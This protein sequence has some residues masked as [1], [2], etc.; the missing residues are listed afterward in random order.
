MLHFDSMT[1]ENFGPYEG[2]Q[3]IDFSNKKGV[4]IIWGNNGRG[5]TTLLNAFRYALFNEVFRR[6]GRLENIYKMENSEAAVRGEHGFSVTL[7]M[8]NDD[9]H[10]ELTR[11]YMPSAGV[12]SPKD[13]E[14][15]EM[16]SFLKK[17]G[18]ILSPEQKEHELNVIMPIEVSRFFLFDA[19][20]LQEYEDLLDENASDGE[21]IKEA[22]ERILGL[23]VLRNGMLDIKNKLD[24]LDRAKKNLGRNNDKAKQYV[25]ELDVMDQQI[26]QHK[27]DIASHKDTLQELKNQ[28]TKL[29]TQMAS[30]EKVRGWIAE[31]K[32]ADQEIERVKHDLTNIESSLK[33]TLGNAWKSMLGTTVR[34]MSKKIEDEKEVLESKKQRRGVADHFLREMRSAVAEKVCPVCGQELSNFIIE[35][36]KKK[37]DE[38]GNEFQGL[39]DAE[40]ERLFTLNRQSVAVDDLNKMIGDTDAKSTIASLEKKRNE[41]NIRIDSLRQQIDECSDNIKRS[42]LQES[43]DVIQGYVK[44]YAALEAKIKAEQTGIAEQQK[45]LDSL[46]KQR[47][48]ISNQLDRISASDKDFEKVKQQYEICKDLY[49]IFQE[50][51]DAYREELKKNVEADASSFFIQLR[52]DPDYKALKINDNYGLEIIHKSGVIIPGRSSGYEHLVALSLIGALHKNAPLRGPII[53]DSP[54]GRLDPQNKRN[55][56]RTLPSMADQVILLAYTDEIDDQIARS[57]LGN[58]LLA[59]YSLNRISSMHTEINTL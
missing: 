12:T 30:T 5:K 28:M 38:S 53:I 7:K 43:E 2:R 36:L 33:E 21:Q 34:D 27:A 20:L 41:D 19:E 26:T 4:T 49:N 25:N 58:N 48:A 35:D 22:I 6:N 57:E 56:I 11:A 15:Y 45:T 13:D 9:N 55:M 1:L 47:D 52:G 46:Q 40:K 24:E 3:T 16:T 8:T 29:E 44:T 39:T 51:K 23:P 50:S 18:S 37:I 32:S 59:E 54:F 31:R 17:N 10:Y 42:G 14:D